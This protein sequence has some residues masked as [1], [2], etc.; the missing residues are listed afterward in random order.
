MGGKMSVSFDGMRIH[1]VRAFND[2]FDS[3]NGDYYNDK[4]ELSD[5]QKDKLEELKCSIGGMLCLF[6][7]DN[8][9]FNMIY[10]DWK[11]KWFNE[12]EDEIL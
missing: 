3:L 1:Q 5:D 4:V 8:E 2:F 12:E 9:T 6:D 11:L 10:D 7:N